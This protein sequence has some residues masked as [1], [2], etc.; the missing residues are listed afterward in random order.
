MEQIKAILP[1][2]LRS[3][4]TPTTS[5]PGMFQRS[6]KKN[7]VN[8]K[9]ATKVY[10]LWWLN[11]SLSLF[12]V[13]LWYPLVHTCTLLL[14]LSNRYSTTT[15]TAATTI[16]TVW[17]NVHA[18]LVICFFHLICCLFRKKFQKITIQNFSFILVSYYL[19]MKCIKW[20]IHDSIFHVYCCVVTY[21]HQRTRV[22]CTTSLTCSS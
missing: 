18:A 1:S 13:G 20:G 2:R 8:K 4:T 15:T 10:R 5:F 14:A 9:Q 16:L 17:S 3:P 21:L 12:W 7:V 22:A 6:G 19:T 11:D